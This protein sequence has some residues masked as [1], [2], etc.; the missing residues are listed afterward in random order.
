[1][2]L[3]LTTSLYLDFGLHFA[4]EEF[5]ITRDEMYAI[6]NDIA[7]TGPDLCYTVSSCDGDDE[8][9]L[10]PFKY[11]YNGDGIAN[12]TDV[13]ALSSHVQE[14][15]AD[16]YLPLDVDVEVIGA[17][18]SGSVDI[19]FVQSKL[20]N[21]AAYVFVTGGDLTVGTETQSF[22]A[23]NEYLYGLA[24]SK[25]SGTSANATAEVAIN[26]AETMFNYVDDEHPE[27]DFQT[28]TGTNREDLSQFADL[29]RL[30]ESYAQVVA[31][32]AA[33]EAFHTFSFRHVR[34]DDS[35]PR[36][37][38]QGSIIVEIQS[39]DIE[40]LESRPII[41]R[42]DNWPIET[43]NPEGTSFSSEPSV[44]N[45]YQRAVNILGPRDDDADGLADVVYFTG[46]PLRDCID[47][48]QVNDLDINVSIRVL[49]DEV[50]TCDGYYYLGY[51]LYEDT[52]TVHIGSDA[53][54][55]GATILID[56]HLGDDIIRVNG[57]LES[58]DNAVTVHIRGGEGDDHIEFLTQTPSYVKIEGE[59]GDDSV[60]LIPASS[61]AGRTI[62]FHGGE[63][64]DQ[65][66]VNDE[67]LI[68]Y[69]GPGDD[70]LHGGSANDSLDGGSGS[71][72]LIGF[73]GNDSLT[74]SVDSTH[75]RMEGRDGD[76]YIVGGGGNNILWGGNGD[77][78]VHSVSES[79]VNVIS[80][81]AGTDV[82]ESQGSVLDVVHET[83]LAV[84]S[85]NGVPAPGI[86]LGGTGGRILVDTDQAVEFDTAITTYLWLEQEGDITTNFRK[87]DNP[88]FPVTFDLT[89]G[90]ANF[91]DNA[92]RPEPVFGNNSRIST[93]TLNHGGD[94]NS[95]VVFNEDQDLADLILGPDSK[96]TLNDAGNPD[97]SVML[98]V[99][100]WAG[101]PAI[102]QGVEPYNSENIVKYGINHVRF[103]T[104]QEL[105]GAQDYYLGIR[106]TKDG[107][108][109]LDTFV[110]AMDY[111]IWW[112]NRFP[113]PPL[114]NNV[115]DT[116]WALADFNED[117]GIDVTDF[118]VWNA[119]KSLMVSGEQVAAIV[120]DDADGVVYDTDPNYDADYDFNSDSTLT[121][122]DFDT[123]IASQSSIRVGDANSDGFVDAQDLQL[124]LVYFGSTVKTGW[125]QGDFNGDTKTDYA[126]F[127]IWFT[128]R[129]VAGAGGT[130]VGDLNHSGESTVEEAITAADIDLMFL[131]LFSIEQAESAGVTI[132][133]EV[134]DI[135]DLNE[136]GV[137]D[138][139]DATYLIE[140]IRGTSY[141]DVNLDGY[142][143]VADFGIINSYLGTY[144]TSWGL[145]DLNGDGIVDQLDLDLYF[146]N[147]GS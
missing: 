117:G 71:N 101:G 97:V 145:G 46:S 32:I 10:R 30:N 43:Q 36:D 42:S 100:D 44:A 104:L 29:D 25:D 11:D 20:I 93:F 131:G 125:A 60:T 129:D 147:Y 96:I 69:G 118:N 127:F 106:Q 28:P 23:R 73:A 133:W 66:S 75:N 37:V 84:I 57:T 109:N 63:G 83:G 92:G 128:E 58:H 55:T 115:D 64:D 78:E 112:A 123:Y 102:S 94:G 39:E 136:D 54:Y 22:A 134:L 90:N 9:T 130:I 61:G 119:N 26:Y 18:A 79:E 1:M 74:A 140:D 41:T 67:T 70:A 146:A 139:D 48:T 87:F 138:W 16:V 82:I 116:D 88:L 12:L 72:I 77:D 53:E 27:W 81:G 19:P 2:K 98:R 62:E 47:I 89:D 56:G 121:I 59:G 45:L 15:V 114:W 17:P 13:M 144:V 80:G 40:G 50:D 4:A 141:G 5:S 105:S 143:N 3:A 124:L 103:G 34:T 51:P 113:D 68:A 7:E 91:L 24:G 31:S 49:R 6:N 132:T 21:G 76:D 110:D 38:D 8:A 95:Q 14:I 86:A 99:Y 142:V 135:Y 122:A 33:H 111:N 137:A 52:Y 35:S 120:A 108:A 85:P 107:D 65:I 126:D